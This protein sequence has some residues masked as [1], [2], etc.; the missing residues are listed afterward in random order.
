MDEGKRRCN[1]TG[2]SRKI[3]TSGG[4][5]RVLQEKRWKN[6]VSEGMPPS[7]RQDMT[8]SA[9]PSQTENLYTRTHAHRANPTE[10]TISTK[11]L[12]ISNMYM[13][14][15]LFTKLHGWIGWI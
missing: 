1:V 13:G 15:H 2:R 14:S 3:R 4:G 5:V 7:P 12:Q 10:L 8:M 9:L 11:M 6:V